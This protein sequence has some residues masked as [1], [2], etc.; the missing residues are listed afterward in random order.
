MTPF[1][2]PKRR[3]N[4]TPIKELSDA[5]SASSDKSP[6]LQAA[7]AAYDAL[8]PEDMIAYKQHC[9]MM[10]GEE[11]GETRSMDEPSDLEPSADEAMPA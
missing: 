11:K 10:E 7:I 2:N 3:S 6:E 5:A 9:D 1:F 8:S 4:S